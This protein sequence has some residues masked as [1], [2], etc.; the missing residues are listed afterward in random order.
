MMQ[1]FVTF[2]AGLL[3]FAVASAIEEAAFTFPFREIY[4]DPETKFS[5]LKNAHIAGA[6]GV[7]MILLAI[8]FAEGFFYEGPIEKKIL[9][10][11]L[12]AVACGL[13]YT[14]TFD[15]VYAKQIGQHWFYLGETAQSD[16]NW[17]KLF[18]RFAGEF[19]AVICL[20]VIIGINLLFKN[21]M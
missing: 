6:V 11:F 21:F 10:G 8:A 3:L 1:L 4:F 15:P 19:K 13:V 9:A 14:F 18:G 17:K 5:K 20:A 7:G 12:C 16:N 2:Q